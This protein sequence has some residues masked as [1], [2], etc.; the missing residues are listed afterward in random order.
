MTWQ[1]KTGK[2]RKQTERQPQERFRKELYSGGKVHIVIKFS[3]AAKVEA[4]SSSNFSTDFPPLKT[5]SIGERVVNLGAFLAEITKKLISFHNPE[6]LWAKYISIIARGQW[7]M[8]LVF[9]LLA[10][11][12]Q[13]SLQGN[14]VQAHRSEKYESCEG[15][16]VSGTDIVCL[17]LS[18][19]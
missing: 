5:N 14:V 6:L 9:I 2:Q 12:E 17:L 4:S 8:Y 3:L 19:L 13:S 15:R 10:G 16:L 1:Q 11:R 7:I 18:V